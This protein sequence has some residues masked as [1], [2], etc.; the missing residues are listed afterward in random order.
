MSGKRRVWL[1]LVP[2][3]GDTEIISVMGHSTPESWDP[4]LQSDHHLLPGG[5]AFVHD[6]SQH[7][8]APNLAPTHP[9][10]GISVRPLWLLPV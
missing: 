4:P 2:L 3:S 5:S 1:L 9:A 8:L 7:Q 10:S 6:A